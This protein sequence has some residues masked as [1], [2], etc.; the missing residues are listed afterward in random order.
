MLRHSKFLFLLSF[1]LTLII[2]THSE[3]QIPGIGPVEPVRRVS[4]G[5]GFTEGP[6]SDI[7]GN[8]YFTDVSRSRIHKI[9]LQA[10]VSTFL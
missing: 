6:A 10:H 5:F 7:K 1:I 8:I 2:V 4:T 3:A 9:D